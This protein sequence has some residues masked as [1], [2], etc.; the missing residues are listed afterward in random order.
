VTAVA[1]TGIGVVSAYG[2]GVAPFWEGLVAGTSAVRPLGRARVPGVELGAE[3]PALDVRTFAHTPL[4][5]RIDRTSLLALAA[6]RLALADAGE[7][8]AATAPERTSLVLGSALGNLGETE[9]F[10]DRL[11]ERG[12]GIP[13]VFPNLVMNAPLSYASIELGVTGPTAFVSEGE[14]S[15]EAAIAWGAGLVADGAADVCLAGGAD[16]LDGVLCEVLRDAHAFTGGTPPGEGAA[17][18]VLEPLA[19]AAARGARVYARLLPHAG[20]AVPAGVH[21]WPRDAGP[22][23]EGLAPL[24]ADAD[25]IVAAANGRAALDRVEA[26]A[27]EQALGPRRPAITALRGA[28]GDFGCAGALATAAAALAI[29]SGT[30][31][32]AAAPPARLAALDLVRGEARRG[33]VRTA[34]VDALARGGLCRPLRLEAA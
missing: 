8:L 17:V 25:L 21:R 5:R 18:L 32:P 33:P 16:E 29:A 1:I 11:F 4:A 28:Y 14:V 10:L 27:L 22:V 26:A 9:V 31:P 13:L 7:P 23:A 19:R 3:A 6:C 20:F 12:A 24:V 30:I 2:V 15:G 34:V